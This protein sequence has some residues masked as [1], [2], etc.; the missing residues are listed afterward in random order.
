MAL[1]TN[2]T[3]LGEFQSIGSGSIAA[4]FQGAFANPSS[5]DIVQVVNEGGTVV[6]NLNYQGVA[7][8]NP[9]SPTL[10]PGNKATCVLQQM[11]GANLAAAI[12][13]AYNHQN[14]LDILQIIDNNGQAVLCHVNNNGLVTQP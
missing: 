8:T 13:S 9:T 5:L 6:W 2:G 7:T 1:P 14:T 3:L 10:G 12:A 11:F 4:I